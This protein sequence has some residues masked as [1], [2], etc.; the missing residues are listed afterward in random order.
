M[1]RFRI[2][3]VG[4]GDVSQHWFDHIAKRNDCSFAALVDVDAGRALAAKEKYGLHCPVF[5]SVDEAMESTEANLLCDLTYVTAHHGIVTKALYA[6]YDVLGEKPMALT[7]EE[8]NEMALAAQKSGRRYIVMQNRR[9]IQQAREIRDLIRSGIMGKPVYVCG[10]IFVGA[11]LRSIRNRLEF[12]QMQD[13]NIHAFDH[14]RFMADADP[15]SVYCHS[16]NPAGSKYAGDA[17]SAAIFEF[18][19]G[20]VF[21]FRGYNGAEGCLTT[22]DHS[23]RI[24]CERGTIVWEGKGDGKYE[25]TDRPGTYNYNSGIIRA[26]ETVRNQHDWALEEM[27]H[28]LSTGEKAPTEYTDNLKSIAMVFGCLKS[29]KEKRK[30]EIKFHDTF[31]YIELI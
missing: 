21:A 29:F 12:P 25:Y 15:V 18:D 1:S 31:P 6:G 27:F 7:V 20:A 11:D 24:C 23:W 9:Y 8:A 30:V 17:A 22:W 16:F 4:C 26:P 28:A 13:N 2:I 14:A 5:S 10:D 19:N 3:L